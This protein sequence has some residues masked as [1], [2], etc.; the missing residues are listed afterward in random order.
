MPPWVAGN[1]VYGRSGKIRKLLEDNGIGYVMR[2]GRAFLVTLAS[3]RRMRADAVAATYLTPRKRGRK[4][5]QT[6]SV[7]GSKG[8]RA[9][10]WAWIATD[11]P[12]HFLLLRKHLQTGEIA[13]H[14][15]WVPAGRKATLM[16]LVRVACLRWP[17]N[18][19]FEFSKDHFG[20]G[21]SQVRKHIALRTH[22]A[23]AGR[24]RPAHADRL[25][26]RRG[27]QRNS[28]QA[29]I[30]PATDRG[31]SRDRLTDSRRR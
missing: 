29:S 11:S 23:V 18:E 30:Q 1:E 20:L 25:G 7:T 31:L 4:R 12:S 27:P 2:V 21:H 15:R 5:W 10:S 22:R 9:Y 19:G 13:Y 6:C 3:G 8:E 26:H 24:V 17:V 16:D 28:Q 14:Y